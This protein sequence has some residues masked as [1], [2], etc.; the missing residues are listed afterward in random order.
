MTNKTKLSLIIPAYNEEKII[1]DTLEHVI[2]YLSEKKYEWEV[3]VVDDGSHDQTAKIANKF[4]KKKVDLV[5]YDIN[6]GKG[7]ALKEG[8]KKAKG[9]FIIFSD[10]DLS[11]DISKIDE[12][13]C[14][15]RNSDV[16]IGS[17]RIRGAKIVVHQP[18]LRELM[19][20]GYTFLTKLVTGVSLAD[21][22]CG[23]KG[24]RKKAAKDIFSKTL[25]NRWAYDSE[26]LFLAKKFKYKLKEIPVEWRNRED[27]RVV[28][29]NV[30]LE[31]LK[32]L[33]AIRVNDL[34]GKYK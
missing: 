23:F 1:K 12:M 19:G 20:R 32:D 16:V 6:R 3:I 18:M 22:T 34:S 24:F 2:E 29:R 14:A 5:R 27:T 8:I 17:R 7:R 31:S 33:I 4:N 30:V 13:L 11:V 21:F 9:D 26:I 25:I 10:A 28:L 15:L